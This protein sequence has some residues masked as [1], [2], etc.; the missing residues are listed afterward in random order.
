MPLCWKLRTIA[1]NVRFSHSR[2]HHLSRA[3]RPPTVEEER[4]AVR[5]ADPSLS[6]ELVAAELHAR[7][8]EMRAY[9]AA[10]APPIDASHEL[11]RR[12]LAYVRFNAKL[13]TARERADA[14][15]VTTDPVFESQRD[16]IVALAASYGT[17]NQYIARVCPGGRPHDL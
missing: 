4:A 16:R 5:L 10:Q 11:R 9:C 6:I 12:F 8:D 13:K 2:P 1:R 17:G 14:L 3:D 7:L 15:L